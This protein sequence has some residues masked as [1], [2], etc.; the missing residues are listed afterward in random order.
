ME[1]FSENRKRSS[2]IPDIVMCYLKMHTD[3][4]KRNKR[5]GYFPDKI[6]ADCNC[7]SDVSPLR[8]TDQIKNIASACAEKLFQKLDSCGKSGLFS[9]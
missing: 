4:E 6:S 7:R 3:C 1:Q 5:R 8:C 2:D 9:S